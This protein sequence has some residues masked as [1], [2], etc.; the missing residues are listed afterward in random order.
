MGLEMDGNGAREGNV[1]E[2]E[3]RIAHYTNVKR[4]GRERRLPL[5]H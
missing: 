3:P 5:D 1:K 2:N 4:A